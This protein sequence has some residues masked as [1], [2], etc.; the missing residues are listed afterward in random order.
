MHTSP[1]PQAYTRWRPLPL[2]SA[3]FLGGFWGERQAVN[4]ASVLHGHHMLEKS[5]TLNNFRLAGRAARGEGTFQGFVF[6]DSDAHKWLEALALMLAL[7]PDAELEALA[8]ETIA[9]L[10]SAQ[11]PDGYLN[12]HFTVAKPGER[13]TDLEWAHEL[14]CAGHLIEAGIA[15]HRA[16]GKTSL[17]D[18]ARRFADHIDSIF[19]PSQRE[20][21][22]G[23]PEIELALVE[24]YRETGEAR[25]LKLASFFVDQRGRG[26]VSGLR[27]VG[28][29]YMQERVPLREAV[30]VEGHAVRQLYLNAGATD[31]YLE[32]GERAWLETMRRLWQDMTTHKMY[33][34]GGFGSRSYGEAFGEAYE[35]PSREAYCETCAAIAAM[36]WNWRMLLATGEARFADAL[37]RSLYNGFLSGVALDGQRFFYENPLQSAGGYERQEWFACACCPP[38]V[39]RQIALVSHYLATTDAT[40]AQTQAANTP[41]PALTPALSPPCA[42]KPTIPGRAGSTLS[43]RPPKGAPGGWRCACRAGARARR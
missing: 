3:Q 20:G 29:G 6:Q 40:G 24:L 11:Q 14:Y 13:W 36:M 42:S 30:V 1:T 10:A 43:S 35:L 22:C 9:L 7:G 39:M 38:N 28:P 8:D 34:T 21:A 37:E 27:H 25:Y 33:L 4:R 31:L 18:I 26:R 23:H 19:G 17:L 2:Q 41:R 16:T 12:S 5:G 32:T 15:H